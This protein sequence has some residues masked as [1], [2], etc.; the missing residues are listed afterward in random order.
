MLGSR[1]RATSTRQDASIFTA[2]S[3]ERMFSP[4][5]SNIGDLTFYVPG[6]STPAVVWR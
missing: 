2:F 5:G 6:T 3:G 4:V 1:I